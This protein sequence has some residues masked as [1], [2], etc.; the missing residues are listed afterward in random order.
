MNILVNIIIVMVGIMLDIMG[1]RGPGVGATCQVR[2]KGP[3]HM[4][5]VE[6]IEGHVEG[7]QF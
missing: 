2:T 7:G 6:G 4:T 5:L 3:P 1:M